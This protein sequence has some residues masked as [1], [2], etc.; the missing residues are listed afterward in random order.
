MR[1][2]QNSASSRPFIAGPSMVSTDR[3]SRRRLR[4]LCDEVLASFRA[5]SEIDLFNEQDRVEGRALMGRIA[6]K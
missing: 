5:A 6:R 3:R 2:Q 1:N 4:D